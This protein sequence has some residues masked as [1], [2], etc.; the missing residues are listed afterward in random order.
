MSAGDGDW[1]RVPAA[2]VFDRKLEPGPLRVLAALACYVSRDGLCWPSIGTLANRLGT[3]ERNV[4]RHI[5]TLEATGYVTCDRQSKGY[6]G[7]VVNTYQ[8]HYP[9]TPK[10]ERVNEEFTL[11]EAQRVNL[12]DTPFLPGGMNMPAARGEAGVHPTGE[13]GVHQRVNLDD[14]QTAHY[15]PTDP[16]SEAAHLATRYSTSPEVD[17][18]EDDFVSSED[19]PDPGDYGFEGYEDDAA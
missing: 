13:P 10:A 9:E 8:L 5:R 7:R 1:S 2:A 6:K 17:A 3:S 11:Y 16:P 4:Q 18:A 19:A 12:D 15:P 14:T